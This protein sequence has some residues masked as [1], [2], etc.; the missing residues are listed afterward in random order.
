MLEP[1]LWL[2]ALLAIYF[3]LAGWLLSQSRRLWVMPAASAGFAAAWAAT[4]AAL[5]ALLAAYRC[6]PLPPAENVGLKVGHDELGCL[7]YPTLL[8]RHRVDGLVPGHGAPALHPCNLLA[9]LFCRLRG[10]RL[11]RLQRSAAFWP[12]RS[13]VCAHGVVLGSCAASRL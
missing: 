11:R 1:F 13:M 5:A 10:P 7:P 2:Q 6:A 3:F 12:A 8:E 4:D 9:L